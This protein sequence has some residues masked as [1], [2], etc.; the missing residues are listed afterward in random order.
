[1]LFLILFITMMINLVLHTALKA[2]KCDKYHM[3]TNHL[4]ITSAFLIPLACSFCYELC[5]AQTI[6]LVLFLTSLT[7]IIFNGV[8]AHYKEN[9]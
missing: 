9:Q 4:I 5:L 8:Y 1:M 6:F 3:L 7:L 2:F